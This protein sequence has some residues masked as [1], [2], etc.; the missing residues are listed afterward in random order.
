MTKEIK[1]IKILNKK[2]LV[3]FKYNILVRFFFEN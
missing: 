1:Y 2:I 3:G